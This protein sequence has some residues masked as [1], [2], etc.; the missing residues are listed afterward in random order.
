MK[1]ISLFLSALLIS[2]ISMAATVTMDFTSAA[3][4]EAIGIPYPTKT[5]DGGAF[6]SNLVIGQAYTQSGVALTVTKK[7]STDTRIWLAAKGTMDLRH[8]KGG[9][10]NF[11][12]PAGNVITKIVFAGGSITGLENLNNKTWEGTAPSVDIP[13]AAGASTIKINTITITYEASGTDVVA[14]PIIRGE[15]DFRKTSEISIEAAAG[16]EVYYT[17]DGT[18]PTTASTKYAAPFTISETTTVKAIAYDA[19]KSK[20]S[21]VVSTTFSKMQTLT[22]AEAAALCTST[23]TDKKYI[24]HGYVTEIKEAYN[25][26]YG[27]ISFWM[28]D[29]KNGGQVLQAFRAKPVSEVEKNLQVG[30][31]VEVIGTLVLYYSTPEV[32]AGCSVE[33]IEEPGTS[34]VDNVVINKQATKFFENGQLVIMKDGIR[35]NAQ[36]QVL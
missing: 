7:G 34:A 23:A 32:N 24:I 12:A 9:V 26:Q 18:D 13:A 35:Y 29:T 27:N 36:G 20:A 3:G 21:E 31:Y 10:L 11:T 14:T 15:N 2:A 4:L 17:L 1:K 28:A 5:E 25:T 33:K 22:C 19:A 8:Y 30:D 6:S 16:M